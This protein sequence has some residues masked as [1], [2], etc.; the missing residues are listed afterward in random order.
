MHK[1][2]HFGYK[3]RRAT[4]GTSAQVPTFA[5][6]R[7]AAR[8]IGQHSQDVLLYPPDLALDESPAEGGGW[9]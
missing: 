2:R 5:H 3:D 1:S 9:G 7:P 8:D 6:F 4:D